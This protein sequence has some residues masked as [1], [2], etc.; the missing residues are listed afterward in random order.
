MKTT[1]IEWTERVWNPSVGCDKVSAGC[2]NCYAEVFARR[3]QAASLK[4]YESGFSFKILPHRLYEPLKIKKPSKFFVNSMSDL[5]HEKMPYDF[6]DQV[7]EVIRATPHHIYQIL[8]KR[9]EI[10]VD[11]FKNRAIPSNVWLGVSVENANYKHRITSLKS[12]PATIRFV[13]FEPLIGPLGE[14]DFEGI[15]W[16]IIGGESGKRARPIKQSWI[17]QIFVQCKQQRVAFFFKQWGT[18]G[19]DEIKRSKKDNGRIFKGKLWDEYPD[20]VCVK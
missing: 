8:T 2:K 14:I 18:W 3:L 20:V 5:F 9:N 17:E 15:H 6:L 10:M 1:N 4:D 7:F 19:A 16:A 11:Y 12:V 13:S